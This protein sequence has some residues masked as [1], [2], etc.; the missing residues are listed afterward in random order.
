[1][2]IQPPIIGPMVLY[3]GE[4]PGL[5]VVAAPDLWPKAGGQ[6]FPGGRFNGLLAEP[7]NR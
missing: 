3:H 5:A 2:V 4:P 7:L 6:L 1:M